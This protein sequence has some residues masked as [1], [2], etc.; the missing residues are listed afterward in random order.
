MVGKS[1]L[2]KRIGNQALRD[3]DRRERHESAPL[4]EEQY[5]DHISKLPAR[6]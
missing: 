1:Q 5:D 4:L 6:P 3:S 2:E